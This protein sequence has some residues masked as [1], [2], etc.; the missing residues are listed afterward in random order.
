LALVNLIQNLS[1]EELEEIVKNRRAVPLATFAAVNAKARI[2]APIC[3]PNW[4]TTMSANQTALLYAINRANAT[5]KQNGLFTVS[6]LAS[7]ES[8]T[9]GLIAKTYL[10]YTEYNLMVYPVASVCARD[11]MATSQDWEVQIP[12]E[13][14]MARLSEESLKLLDFR[15]PKNLRED[16]ETSPVPKPITRGRGRPKKSERDLDLDRDGELTSAGIGSLDVNKILA[17]LGG[18][19]P[20]VTQPTSTGTDSVKTS[21]VQDDFSVLAL[22]EGIRIEKGTEGYHLITKESGVTGEERFESSIKAM[23]FANQHKYPR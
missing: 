2:A 9:V 11:L 14:K 23:I 5:G 21:R 22:S 3:D 7:I 12:P 8:I 20:A 4:H 1:A 19:K 6:L 13:Q 16:Y 18:K 17:A 10:K 15:I